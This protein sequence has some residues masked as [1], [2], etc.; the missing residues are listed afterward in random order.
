P[1]VTIDP[2]GSMD[3]D[4]AMYLERRTGGG[5]RVHYAIADVAA[6]VRPGGA[7]ERETWAR[8]ETVYLPDGNVPLHPSVLSEGAVSL[9]P[10]QVRAAVVWTIDVDADGGPTDVQVERAAIRSRAKLNYPAVQ[11]DIA[12]GSVAEPIALLPELGAL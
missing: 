4:Q 12:K 3:L 11:A 10:D 8:G 5:Y 9:L 6:Y 1:F 2:P 7:L